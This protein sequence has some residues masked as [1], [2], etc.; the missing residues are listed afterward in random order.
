MI[1]LHIA[2]KFTIFYKTYILFEI[3]MC[4]IINKLSQ[5]KFF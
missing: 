1:H 3:T 2:V 5:L 4:V